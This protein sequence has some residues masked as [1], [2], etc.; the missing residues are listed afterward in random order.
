MIAIRLAPW[1]YGRAGSGIKLFMQMAF[2]ASE[3][4]YIDQ[5]AQHTSVVHVDDA[6]RLFL[7]AAQRARAGDVFNCTSS[8]EVTQRQLAEA[9]GAALAVPVNSRTYDEQMVKAGE[10]LTGFLTAENRS[11]SA[12]AVRELR[13]QPKQRGILEDITSG[14]YQALAQELRKGSA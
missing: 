13:W 8:T 9:M 11:S 5:G 6:A 14:S 3:V 12:K 2:G 7:L 10:F 1:V 4:I